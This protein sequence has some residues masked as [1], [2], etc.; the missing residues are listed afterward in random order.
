MDASIRYSR[1]EGFT[2]QPTLFCEFHGSEAGVA[3]QIA[4]FRAITTDFGAG[5]MRFA[6]QTEDRTRLWKARHNAW[7]AAKA[8]RPG[9][10]AFATDACVPISQLARVI[11]ETQAEITEAGLVA[12]L[13]GH[14]G[15]GNFHMLLLYDPAVPAERQRAEALAQS[16]ARRAIAAGG[17][18]TGEHGIGLHKLGLLEEE[19]GAGA[20]RQ[21]AAIKRAL[22]PGNILN[23][24]KTVPLS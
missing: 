11:A 20:L 14:V 4:T 2:A 17:T 21:M 18:A 10:E 12:P 23:P 9:C 19:H 15:D 7:F 8:L 24:G 6:S 5:E 1:L 22:D 13:V 16:I 3:E